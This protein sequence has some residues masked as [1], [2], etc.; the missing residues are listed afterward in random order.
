MRRKTLTNIHFLHLISVLGCHF[1]WLV[2]QCFVLVTGSNWAYLLVLL[3]CFLGVVLEWVLVVILVQREEWNSQLS[4]SRLKIRF[5]PPLLPFNSSLRAWPRFARRQLIQ[6]QLS[7][8]QR[9]NL[10]GSDAPG[11]CWTW[12]CSTWCGILETS[13]MGDSIRSA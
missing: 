11:I 10:R 1:Y 5:S 6:H 13:S 9:V 7:K 2:S 4:F 12:C 3:L 8:K